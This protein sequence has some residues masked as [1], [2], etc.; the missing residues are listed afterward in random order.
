MKPI[1]KPINQNQKQMMG[2]LIRYER[3]QRSMSQEDLVKS[4]ICSR[5]TLSNIEN[6]NIIKQDMIYY[7]LL[8]YFKK[9]YIPDSM[10]DEQFALFSKQLLDAWM[11]QNYDEQH[12]EKQ[13]HELFK[14]KRR[15]YYYKT[16]YTSM[17]L[18]FTYVK[19][20]SD[21][22][23]F[24]KYHEIM[25][26][27]KIYPEPMRIILLHICFR[28][29]CFYKEDI[30]EIKEKK[31]IY[32]TYASHILLKM[33]LYLYDLEVGIDEKM[34]KRKEEIIKDLKDHGYKEQLYLFQSQCSVLEQ[35]L[36]SK[37]QRKAY[38][39]FY[40]QILKDKINQNTKFHILR[41]MV[42]LFYYT[43]S[44]YEK[45][46]EILEYLKENDPIDHGTWYDVLWIL[47][48][49]KQQKNIQLKQPAKSQKNV[50]LY[51][52]YLKY[53]EKESTEVLLNYIMEIILPILKQ[54]KTSKM[55]AI[56]KDELEML[57][58]RGES[59]RYKDYFDYL[60]QTK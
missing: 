1:Y 35:T 34:I 23:P 26:T 11:R 45:T 17:M 13:I 49:E 20:R 41:N 50:F 46:Y 55:I 19:S 52:Y 54:H 56:F 57:L 36:Y 28:N 40:H 9:I 38:V 37:E 58:L 5:A 2:I 25:E 59:K 6:G 42:N 44:D 16:L 39:S 27:I 15:M 48:K 53:Q 21:M 14:K 51:Y 12:L 3:M 4:H 32:Q 7:E 22:L 60:L 29:I 10:W 33:D 18:V 8:E 30:N 43:F 47:C 24:H 31:S